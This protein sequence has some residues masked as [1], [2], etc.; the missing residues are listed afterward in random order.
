M[1]TNTRL[2]VIAGVLL[3][4]VVLTLAVLLGVKPM[5]DA[6]EANESQS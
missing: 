6:A 1:V 4:V 2:W 3:M 5:L